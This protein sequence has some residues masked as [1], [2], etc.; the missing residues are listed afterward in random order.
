MLTKLRNARLVLLTAMFVFFGSLATPAEACNRIKVKGTVCLLPALD[1]LGNPT[2]ECLFPVQYK[3]TAN[4]KTGR[5]RLTG[6]GD[7]SNLSRSDVEM[8]LNMYM[9]DLI[10]GVSDVNEIVR[11]RVSVNRRGKAKLLAVFY[12][13]PSLLDDMN[14]STD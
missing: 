2:G 8:I 7:I 10:D 1:E 9:G 3:I 13:D 4:L 14:L 5:V 6:E 12:V 11:V